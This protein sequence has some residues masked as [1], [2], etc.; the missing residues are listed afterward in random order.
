VLFI[1]FC[2]PAKAEQLPQIFVAIKIVPENVRAGQLIIG[3]GN[4]ST[5]TSSSLTFS[6][7]TLTAG[8]F[9]GN[10]SGLT[11]M[12]TVSYY[13][14][15]TGS[16]AFNITTRAAKCNLQF[17]ISNRYVHYTI[18][19][20]VIGS[21]TSGD[22]AAGFSINDMSYFLP[23]MTRQGGSSDP[24]RVWLFNGNDTPVMVQENWYN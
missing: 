7:T 19:N 6:G 16:A 1:V 13:V 14:R 11:N 17:Y 20:M 3:N 23:Y 12:L 15:Y 21:N 22:I 5:T 24:W 10:G 2:F 4:G 8:N 9:V 18:I